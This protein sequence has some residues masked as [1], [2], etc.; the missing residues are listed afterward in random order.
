[1]TT[2]TRRQ[3]SREGTGRR[4]TRRDQP[5]ASTWPC[6]A[7]SWRPPGPCASRSSTPDLTTARPVRR[8]TTVSSWSP[9]PRRSTTPSSTSSAVRPPAS[10]TGRVRSTSCEQLVRSVSAVLIAL[11][12]VALRRWA[13]TRWPAV[14][15]L[16]TAAPT[17]LYTTSVAAPNGVEVSA[18]MLVWCALLGLVASTKDRSWFVV[19][20]TVGAVPLVTVRSVGPLW[21]LLTVAAIVPLLGGRRLRDLLQEPRRPRLHRSGRVRHRR[22]RRM[23]AGGVDQHPARP[24][25]PRV[26]PAAVWSALPNETVLWVLQNVGAFPSRDNAAPPI[27]YAMVLGAWRLYRRRP[28][29]RAEARAADAGGGRVGVGSVPIAATV[30]TYDT[31]GTSWQ[32]R[33][34][35][36]FTMGFLLI[37]GLVL[38]RARDDAPRWLVWAAAALITT[39]QTI[40]QL[41]RAGGR[42][43]SQPAFRH[44]RMADSVTT[45]GRGPPGRGVCRLGLR[46]VG[47]SGAD[48]C[49]LRTGGR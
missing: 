49:S 4:T 12:A 22:R 43:G 30:A 6:R 16:L 18:A 40:G 3:R 20:A 38:D 47:P 28:A 5:A 42:E 26:E 31:F 19:M 11:A 10:S 33:Y 29:G 44:G 41:C 37:C 8:R 48:R 45:A 9:P 39:A 34:G 46:P 1:M 7:T 23:V 36:P 14:A 17:M 35:Y 15:F 32:G 24:P 21:L 27:V 25:N 13:R 2:R